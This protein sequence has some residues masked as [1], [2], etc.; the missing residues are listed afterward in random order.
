MFDVGTPI[1]GQPGRQICVLFRPAK[2]G[3]Q[4]V[5]KIRYG[6]GCSASVSLK[7]ENF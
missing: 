1:P 6:N 3:D 2:T 5:I 4:E 7:K